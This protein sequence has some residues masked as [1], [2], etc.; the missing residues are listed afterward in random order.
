MQF[1][2]SERSSY[3]VYFF[4]YCALG[5]FCPLIG[6]YLNSIGFT[7][8]QVGIV[9]SIGTIV[10][11]PSGLLWGKIYANT[12]R[13]I[14]IIIILSL[15]SAL[16]ALISM[17]AKTFPLYSLMYG[18]MYFFQGPIHGFCDSMMIDGGKDFPRIRAFGALGYS[19]SVLIAGRIA[20]SFGLEVILYMY[21][22]AFIIA[23]FFVSKEQ[24]PPSLNLDEDKI[25][26]GELLKNSKYIKLLI[27]SFFVMGAITTLNTFFGFLYIEVGGSISGIGVAFLL[28]TGCEAPMMFLI[29][30]L[31]EKI[32][33]QKLILAA[34][35][36]QFIRQMLMGLVP[37]IPLLMGTFF[38]QGFSNGVILVEIVRYFS[39]VVD[40]R[41]TNIAVATFYA[42]GNSTSIIFCNLVG[43]T[44]LDE[45]GP[46]AVFLFFGVM[47]L[48]GIV[49]YKTL[50]LDLEPDAK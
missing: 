25:K 46:K 14:M 9:M 8:T 40:P 17:G 15:S 34:M 48:I 4:I 1:T 3:A 47:T 7:G 39:Q 23:S 10:A 41:L 18:I 20:Q 36:V 45:F 30:K 38:M 2:K 27:C 26:I 29:P 5:V 21:A 44:V 16:M 11:V 19:I 43:G 12:K 35:I 31:R 33:P 13:K 28:M 32:S 42:I 22:I 24:A 37:S 49:L 50:K 6:Q